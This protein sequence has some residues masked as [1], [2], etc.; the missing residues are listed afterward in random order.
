MA[1]WRGACISTPAAVPTGRVHAHST[2]VMTHSSRLFTTVCTLSLTLAGSAFA[3]GATAAPEASA[4][5]PPAPATTSSRFNASIPTFT[6][7]AVSTPSTA[8]GNSAA[9]PV[10][11]AGPTADAARAG[12]APRTSAERTMNMAADKHIGAGQNVALMV[13]G[14]AALIT[15]LI[16]GGDGGALVAIGGA[17]V[18]L[19]GLYN[20][21]K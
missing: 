20:Y 7:T 10:Q 17:A 6:P 18:G 2:P 16:I 1:F 3:Q 12:I 9:A 14:G 21:I 11:P 5:L 19:V 8:Q 15:G 13:V 4:T